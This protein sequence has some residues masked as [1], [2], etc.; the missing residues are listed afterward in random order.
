MTS[1]LGEH[2]HIGAHNGFDWNFLPLPKIWKI[3]PNPDPKI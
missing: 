1:G 3:D 2:D